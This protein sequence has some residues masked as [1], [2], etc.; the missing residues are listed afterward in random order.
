[1][2]QISWAAQEKRFNS[3]QYRRLPASGDFQFHSQDL[4]KAMRI[5]STI[6]TVHLAHQNL[7]TGR[8]SPMHEESELTTQKPDTNQQS[9]LGHVGVLLSLIFKYAR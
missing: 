7:R 5:W 4:A 1:M 6:E 8:E 3:L 9:K 2:K